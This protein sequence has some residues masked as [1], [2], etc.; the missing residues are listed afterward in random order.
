MRTSGFLTFHLRISHGS[1]TK[2]PKRATEFCKNLLVYV[3]C[4]LEFCVTT[5]SSAS[6]K[7][8]RIFH[9]PSLFPTSDP[10]LFHKFWFTSRSTERPRSVNSPKGGNITPWMINEKIIHPS[11]LIT[12]ALDCSTTTNSKHKWYQN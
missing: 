4:V 8:P 11:V 2:Y 12:V 9:L 1:L 10:R 7:E 3:W 5:S 6:L